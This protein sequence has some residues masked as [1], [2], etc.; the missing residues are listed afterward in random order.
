MKFVYADNAATT[1]VSPKVVEAMLP[2][3]TENYGNPSSLYAFGVTAAHAIAKARHQV[4]SV[5]N[6]DDGEVFFTSGGSESDN[7]AIRGAAH[8][9]AKKGKK[10]IISTKME[11]HAVLHTLRKLEKDEGFEVT[12]LDIYDNGIVKAEDVEKA[13]REDTCLVTVMYA[14]NEIG[15]IQPIAEIGRICKEKNVIFHTDAVQAVGHIPI[16]VKAENID[17]LSLSGHKFHAVKGTGALYCKKG[18]RLE[19]LIEGGGQEKGRRAGT[20]NVPGIVGLGTAITEMNEHLEENAK[21]VSALRDKLFSELTKISHSRING[22][23]EKRLPG[24]FNMSF[25]G[26]EGESLLLYLDLQGVCASSGS[27]CTSGSL[28]PSHVL[29]ALGLKHEVA[30]GSLRLSLGELNTEE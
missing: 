13:I 8:L 1:A 12:Y 14:N 16:D 25:E 20:E 19:N 30:H 2:Y 7:W 9:G 18:I 10:H 24:N 21:K 11:H 26:V 3:M 4:A 17:M 15:T 27:A 23:R 5:L 6:C 22:D 28:D 29:L